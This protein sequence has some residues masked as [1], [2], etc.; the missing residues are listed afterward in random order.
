[1]AQATDIDGNPVEITSQSEAAAELLGEESTSTPE[2]EDADNDDQSADPSEE[3]SAA[4]G[5][6]DELSA[7]EIEELAE[8]TTGD[9]SAKGL[10]ELK[11]FID[12]TYKGDV[13]A[14]IKG[15]HNNNARMKEFSEKLDS[16]EAAVQAG[17]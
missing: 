3:A 6:V 15:W 2:P 1:M 16:I 13:A 7:E 17:S 5:D 14:F 10:K 11:D 4:E 8:D 12:K 9:T